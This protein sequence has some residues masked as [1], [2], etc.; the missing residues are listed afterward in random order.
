MRNWREYLARECS[1]IGLNDR[2]SRM[3]RGRFDL[4]A[5][6]GDLSR[7]NVIEEPHYIAVHRLC[8]GTDGNLNIRIAL[9][10]LIEPRKTSPS[11]TRTLS[12]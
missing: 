2:R 7:A 10:K 12:K 3:Q 4:V 6:L 1:R 11:S 8:F 9:M 5:D